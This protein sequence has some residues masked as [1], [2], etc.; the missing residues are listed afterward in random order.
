MIPRFVEFTDQLPRTPNLKVQKA[1]LRNRPL[2]A[3][4]W[5]REAAGIALPR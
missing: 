5:D 3:K 2:D 4:L 1:V